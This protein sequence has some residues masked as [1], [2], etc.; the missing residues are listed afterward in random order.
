MHKKHYTIP[1][2]VPEMACPFRC[3]YCDQ[4][5]ISG[6]KSIPSKEDVII[7]IEKYLT[8]ISS[9]DSEVEVGFFGGSFTGIP[10][11]Q[12]KDYLEQVQ[13]Y[14]Q[15][16][17]IHSIRLST[18]PD[19]ITEDIL[20]LLKVYHVKTI[21][22]GAQS[23]DN[24]VL[25]KCNRGHTFEDVEKAST[26]IKS[27]GFDLGLQ[28]MIGL[29]GDNM[30]KSIATAKK[31]IDLKADN[32]RIYPTIV[33]K[34][35]YLEELYK[36]GKYKALSLEECI[37]TLKILIPLFEEANVNIIKVG[38]HPS[39][40]LQQ[41]AYVAGPYH[42][43]LRELVETDIWSEKFSEISLNPHNY[44]DINLFIPE[45]QYNFAIGYKAKNRISLESVFK[46][47][48]FSVDNNLKNREFYVD[49][50]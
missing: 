28:M 22:L 33:I 42:P 14:I 15:K 26:L 44:S 48:K 46:K 35:T 8:T 2:F 4:H 37:N 23:L 29:P 41:G 13:P 38:L 32:T 1:I 6:A 17:I 39:K 49:F 24:E 36:K 20:Q 10:A 43:S 9:T 19:Y 34:G 7:T 18:R 5:L 11:D 50:G 12:Q 45:K 16:G 30:S 27:F 47:V 21:E 40:D 31:I 3:I 25:E